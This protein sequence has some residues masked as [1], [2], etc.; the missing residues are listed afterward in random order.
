MTDLLSGRVLAGKVE[1]QP[2]GVLVARA[3][4]A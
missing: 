2:Y 3:D 1:M 4:G